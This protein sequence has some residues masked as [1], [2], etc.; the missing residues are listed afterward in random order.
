[1]RMSVNLVT[2]FLQQGEYLRY[3][4]GMKSF[5]SVRTNNGRIK[6]QKRLLVSNI[7]ELFIESKYNIQ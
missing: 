4:P 5:V 1:M 7:K 3:C 6:H 2:H